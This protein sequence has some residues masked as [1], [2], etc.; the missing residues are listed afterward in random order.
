MADDVAYQHHPPVAHKGDGSRGD[1]PQQH[2]ARKKL[3]FHALEVCYGPQ[4]RGENGDKQCGDGGADT[5]PI[6]TVAA[7]HADKYGGKDGSHDIG[8][9]NGVGPVVKDPASFLQIKA[10]FIWI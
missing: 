5:P 10:G 3:L 4:N 2:K 8:R 1:D 7:C 6:V 9:I